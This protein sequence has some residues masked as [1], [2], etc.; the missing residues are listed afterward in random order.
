M[1]S[2]NLRA[3]R[4]SDFGRHRML[5]VTSSCLANAKPAVRGLALKHLAALHGMDLTTTKSL[6]YDPALTSRDGINQNGAVRMGPGAFKQGH[7]WLAAVLFHEIVH[8]DQFQFYRRHGI[9]FAKPKNEPE[10]IL[11]ALDECEGFY[12]PY[13]NSKALGLNAVQTQ[14]FRRE[15]QLWTVEIDDRETLRYVKRGAFQEARMALVKRL[16]GQKGRRRMAA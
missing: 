12:R 1:S 3:I 6:R 13:R 15:V 16:A 14:S 10:R 2:Y 8:S 9:S 11:V 4:L 7:E 5:T